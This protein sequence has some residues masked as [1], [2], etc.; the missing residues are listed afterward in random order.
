MSLRRVRR[1]IGK[2][3][4]QARARLRPDPVILI[5]HRVATEPIDPLLLCVEPAHFAEHLEVLSRKY[6]PMAL[7]ELLLLK[8]R[9]RLPAR[10]FVITF[11]DGYADNLYQARPVLEK[12]AVPATVFVVAGDQQVEGSFWWDELARLLLTPG[13]LPQRLSLCLGGQD[14]Q[15]DLSAAAIYGKSEYARYLNWSVQET[16][17]PTPR[18]TLY[19]QLHE[20]LRVLSF[21]E[22]GRS[23]EQLR[24]WA[25]CGEGAHTPAARLTRDETLALAAD[26]LVDIGAHTATHPVLA[27]LPEAVQASELKSSRSCLEDLLGRPVTTFSYPYGRRQDYTC[28]TVAAVRAAGFVGACANFPGPVQRATDPYQLPRLLVRNW[29]GDEFARELAEWLSV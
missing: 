5:Y 9:S 13:T 28:A 19:R 22:Q 15:W 2:L 20:R 6:R 3:A 8:S 21:A 10:S 16:V 12:Y 23:L 1:R 7:T 4:R 26:G 24:A 11:D 17:D 25:G 27:T 18:H 14:F 29:N